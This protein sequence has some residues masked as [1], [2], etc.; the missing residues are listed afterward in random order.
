MLTA[1]EPISGWICKISEVFLFPLVPPELRAE[2]QLK[3]RNT[4]SGTD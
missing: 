3:G 2:V 1:A 4:D